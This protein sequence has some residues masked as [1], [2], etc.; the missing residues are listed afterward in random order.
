MKQIKKR[1]AWILCMA[2]CIFSLSA[3]SGILEEAEPVDPMVAENLTSQTTMLVSNI[4]SIPQD[5]MS[6]VIDQNRQNGAEAV[7]AGLES[8]MGME[9][10]LGAFVA[11]GGSSVRKTDD[12]YEVAVDMT[13][14]P[15]E[16]QFLLNVD[17]SMANITAMS[18]N[19]V[20]T[21]SENMAKA[22]MNT[23]M[24]MGTVFLVLIF[25]SF[26]IGC[27][28]Y[29][30]GLESKSGAAQKAP[31]PAP[32]AVPAPAAAPAP[33]PVP[34][35]AVAAP[36]QDEEEMEMLAIMTAIIEDTRRKQVPADGLVVR[37]LKRAPGNRWKNRR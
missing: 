1:I 25:I 18:F 11:M 3:C 37:S 36:G 5:Q 33:A 20:Y 7:A 14:E 8:Y 23:L 31:A 17:D 13:F 27:F 9:D 35:T 16:C 15:R 32:A 24:G 19:P 4:V 2:A 28:K 30:N 26:L 21:T 34:L 12:G 6:L 22:A 29:I 10:D